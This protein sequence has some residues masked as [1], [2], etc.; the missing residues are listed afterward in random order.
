[1]IGTTEGKILR[2]EDGGATWQESVVTPSLQLYF[3]RERQPDP[4]MEYALGLPGKSPH[5]QSWIRRQGLTTSGINLQ[6]LLVQKGEKAVAVT[7][8]EVDWRNENKVYVG[9]QN[10]IYRSADKGR[11]FVRAFQGES[12]AAERMVNTVAV[13]PFNSRRV[14]IGTASG[15]FTSED[16]GFTFHKCIDFYLIDAHVREIWFDPEQKGLL[17]VAMAGSAM[18]SP[19]GGKHWITT[20]WN[21]WGP[22]A[23]VTS[24]SLGPENI[25]VIGTRDGVFASFQGGEMGTWKRRG[26]RFVGTLMIKV[27]ATKQPKIWFALTDDAVWMTSDSGSHW[28]KIFQTGGKDSVR[29]ISAFKGDLRHL[30]FLSSREVYRMGTP[31]KMRRTEEGARAPVT[32]LRVPL[33]T[34]LLT[35]ILKHNK[36]YF[37]DTAEY[38]A[39]SSWAA[40]LPEI[41]AGFTYA[42]DRT[43]QGIK[44]FQYMQYPYQYWNRSLEKGAN[45]EITANWDL[46]RLVFDKASMPHWGRVERNLAA[47]RQDLTDKTHRLYLEYR[48]VARVLVYAP[49]ADELA[50]QYLEIRLQ[51]I[52]AYLDGISGGFWGKATGGAP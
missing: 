46:G 25:R 19:D 3:G 7:W 1:M 6:Q 21:D 31:P 17:H 18:A 43:I 16:G 24:L 8:I 40:F 15:L 10:G 44:T 34:E 45:W 28:R 9:T 2:S 14:L 13:D 30:W 41:T 47:I 38:R 5:L 12:S 11:T 51:E 4:R 49:P 35:R 29:W 52:S 37:P 20:H 36:V 27:L 23:D 50:R 22:R 42:P 26:L 33:L 39:R 32:L 48:K